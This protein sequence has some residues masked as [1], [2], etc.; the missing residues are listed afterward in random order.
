MSL[1]AHLRARLTALADALIPA[2]EGMPAAS[3]VDVA[4]RQLD[5]V[6]ASRPDLKDDLRRA[7]DAATGVVD[8]LAWVEELRLADPTAYDALVTAVVGGYY[9]HP[10]VQRRLGY[11]GQVPQPVAADRYPEYADE[12]ERV[13]ERGPLYRPTPGGTARE[14]PA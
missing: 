3:E 1:D 14:Q 8:A 12:L 2:A 11:P 5:L 4:G 13:V 6:L 7:L 10:E 9:L